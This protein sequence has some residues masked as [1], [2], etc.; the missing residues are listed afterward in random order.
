MQARSRSKASQELARST[1]RRATH[2][3]ANTETQSTSPS[4][5]QP[6]YQIPNEAAEADL[7]PPQNSREA[8]PRLRQGSALQKAEQRRQVRYQATSAAQMSEPVT[9]KNSTAAF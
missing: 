1:Q 6:A 4:C 3:H 5:T 8:S 7:P 2:V 9:F